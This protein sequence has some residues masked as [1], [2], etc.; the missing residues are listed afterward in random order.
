MI[1]KGS[2]VRVTKGLAVG[3]VG[4]VLGPWPSLFGRG[5]DAVRQWMIESDDLVRRRILREDHLELVPAAPTVE[6]L[7][8][9]LDGGA[10]NA[11]GAE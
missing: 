5:K 3:V 11:S 9:E 7:A 8:R 10:P 4:V 1:G 2:T 6:R